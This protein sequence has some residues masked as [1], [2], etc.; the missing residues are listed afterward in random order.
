MIAL[1]MFRI[2]V[3][4]KTGMRK[5]YGAFCAN[6]TARGDPNLI[7]I[8]DSPPKL[9]RSAYYARLKTVLYIR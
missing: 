4:H 5:N 7:P 3:G 8:E 2:A 1:V 9:I 6:D